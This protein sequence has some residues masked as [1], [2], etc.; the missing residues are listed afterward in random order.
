MGKLIT[1][2]GGDGPVNEGERRVI[3]TLLEQLP[4]DYWVIPNVEILDRDGQTFEYDAIV[5]APHAVYVLETKDW[6]GEIRID[7]REW[8]VNGKTRKSPLSTTER[9]A[10][11]LKSKLVAVTPALARVWVEAAVILASQPTIYSSSADGTRRVF[12]LQNL[13]PFLTDPK[14]VRQLPRAIADLD[15]AISRALG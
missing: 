14:Q 10:K 3:A 12:Q 15:D 11:I 7:D 1:L 13:V 6:Y 5:I 4:D 8:L 2:A 9:K